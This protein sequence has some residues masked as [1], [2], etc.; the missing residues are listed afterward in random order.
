MTESELIDKIDQDFLKIINN[1]LPENLISHRGSSGPSFYADLTN[2]N[3]IYKG[4]PY[5][6]NSALKFIHWTNVNNLLSIIN[7]REIRLYNLLNS[8]DSKEF[9]YAAKALNIP[10]N[11]IEYSKNYY[12]T[13]SFCS[14]ADLDNKYLWEEYGNNYSGVAI[15]FEILNEPD[16][17][18]NFMLSQVYYEIPDFL[19]DFITEL[20]SIQKEYPFA[21]TRIDLGKFIGYHKEE[22]FHNENEIRLSAYFPFESSKEYLK[23]CN[24]EFRFEKERPR[25]TNY[26]GLPLWVN[27][28]SA[29]IKD[30]ISQYDRRQ[31]VKTD[32]YITNPQIKLTEIYFGKNCGIN[33]YQ[34]KEFRKELE[35]IIRYK[36]GYNLKLRLNLFE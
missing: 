26:F 13:F 4:T 9:E 36:L 8:S 6:Y 1:H 35:E 19:V 27:N 32:F 7:N 33:N 18:K 25:I 30:N 5:F 23:Y 17:W 34:Y 31:N 12:Y 24:K 20:K 2:E 10:Q 28:D 21:K 3:H 22:C 14:S 11:Q 15:E 16:L 29:Y